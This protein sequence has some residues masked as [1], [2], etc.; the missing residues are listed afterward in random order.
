MVSEKEK[1]L[2]LETYL[3]SWE[4]STHGGHLFDQTDIFH[5]LIV[6]FSQNLLVPLG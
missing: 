5:F 2:L 6:L 4:L 3:C 1:P